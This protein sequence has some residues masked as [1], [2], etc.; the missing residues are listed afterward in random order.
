MKFLG[1]LAIYCGHFGENTGR[2]F[3]FVWRYHVPLM[4]LCAGFFAQRNKELSLKEFLVKRISNII[5]PYYVFAACSLAV[6]LILNPITAEDFFRFIVYGIL[7]FKNITYAEP[8]WFLPA[9][10][11]VE[12]VYYF[13]MKI[14]L[15][16]EKRNALLRV[17]ICFAFSCA[18]TIFS[19]GNYNTYF[20]LCSNFACQYFIYYSI[21]NLVEVTCI[22]NKRPISLWSKLPVPSV[23]LHEAFVC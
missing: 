6:Y 10:F 7:G 16:D 14:N 22:D 13:L 1:I 15:G 5:V 12:M 4:F 21:G 3:L 17:V 23:L 20:P 9:L 8:L 11:F 18:A 19:K 2:L